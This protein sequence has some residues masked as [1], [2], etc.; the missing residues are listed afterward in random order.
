MNNGA[1]GEN[2]PYTNFHDLNLDWI[3]KIIKDFAEKY[4]N[5]IEELN[6]KLNKPLLKPDGTLGDVLISNGDGTTSW[7]DMSTE[8]APFIVQAVDE[9]L[10][11]HPDVTTTVENGSITLEK[12][13]DD[14]QYLIQNNNSGFI[15]PVYMGDYIIENNYLPSCVIKRGSNFIALDAPTRTY[16][17]TTNGQGYVKT[18]SMESNSMVSNNTALLGHANSVAFDGTYYYVAPIWKYENNIETPTTELY[19]FDSNFNFIERIETPI[20]PTGVTFDPITETLYIANVSQGNIY[21]YQDGTFLPYSNITMPLDNEFKNTL[22]NQDIAI[23]NNEFYISSSNR[24]ILHGQLEQGTSV[25]TDSFYVATVDSAFRFLMGELEGMEFDENGHLYA[26]MFITLST[27]ECVN[28]FVVELPV[29]KTPQNS[30]NMGGT[31]SVYEGTIG[32]SEDSQ[33]RFYLNT[34]QLRSLLQLEIKPIKELTSAVS[35]D[36]NND[37]IDPWTIRINSPISLYIAGRYTCRT[38]EIFAGNVNIYTDNPTNLLTLTNA[39]RLIK[40]YRSGTLLI[41]GSN[42]LNVYTPNMTS[43]ENDNF[44]YK[45]NYYTMSVIRQAPVNTEDKIM[46]HGFT[47]IRD[48]SLLIGNDNVTAI[49]NNYSTN[50]MYGYVSGASKELFLSLTCPK[51]IHPDPIIGGTVTV[52]TAKGYLDGDAAGAIINLADHPALNI[53]PR[54]IGNHTLELKITKVDESVFTN[55]DNNTLVIA[56]GTISIY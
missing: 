37:V 19:K 6:K 47:T 13:R 56:S 28:A 26:T 15:A 42:R 16:G 1:F 25:A 46:K 18:F 9:W 4:P 2:F 8:Y 17:L 30:T 41:G 29:N 35:I 7:K 21:I 40:V 3:I 48:W 11:E 44:I 49:G 55:V 38:L 24:N 43:N 45:E 52:R 5:V 53:T 39:N 22:Y 51:W 14:M 31:F 20:I 54:I 33:N 50:T 12:L 10:E 27:N 34:T 23:Y 36:A 32:I